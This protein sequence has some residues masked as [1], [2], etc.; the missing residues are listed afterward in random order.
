MKTTTKNIKSNLNWKQC[1]Q[2][3]ENIGKEDL[4]WILWIWINKIFQGTC[5]VEVI[6]DK[7]GTVSEMKLKWNEHFMKF[8]F[9]TKW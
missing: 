8:L 7:K 3:T 9:L 4:L 5:K 2:V 6:K 1:I